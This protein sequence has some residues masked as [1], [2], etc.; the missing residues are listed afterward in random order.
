MR[1]LKNGALNMTTPI[2]N[3][4]YIGTI[5]I[6][7]EAIRKDEGFFTGT[8]ATSAFISNGINEGNTSRIEMFLVTRRLKCP[9]QGTSRRNFV[10]LY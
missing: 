3:E 8:L 9:F 2:R 6:L 7:R 5:D 10:V 1:V 4:F